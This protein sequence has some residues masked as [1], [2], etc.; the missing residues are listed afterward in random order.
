MFLACG[1]G[2]LEGT[3]GE[4]CDDG[5]T[6]ICDGCSDVCQIEVVPIVCGDGAVNRAC[7]EECDL[8][9]PCGLLEFCD[10]SCLCVSLF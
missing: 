10:A 9:W 8:G 2:L 7:G 3:C 5:N 4:T 1:D 6:D